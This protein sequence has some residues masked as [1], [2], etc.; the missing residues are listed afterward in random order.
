MANAKLPVLSLV[1]LALVAPSV[2]AQET[3]RP[4]LTLRE[5]I[6]RA[7]LVQ[8]SVVQALTQVRTA[9]ARILA[10]KGAWL[11]NLTATSSGGE[12][13]SESPRLDPIAGGLTVGG[14]TSPSMNNSVSSSLELFDGFR[15]SAESKAA[16]ANR[17]AMEANLSDARFQQQLTTTNGFF[18]VLAAQQLVRVRKASVGRAQEQLKVS[19]SRLRAGAG[20]RSDSLGSLV[21]LGT[22]QLQL[23]DAQT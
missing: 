20:I 21:T 10:A 19:V 9:D 16:R 12:F 3:A 11:P 14:K 18:D 17:N 8:P 2:G 13:F 23:I 1:A 15:R 5:A 7:D 6:E 4:M 22:A